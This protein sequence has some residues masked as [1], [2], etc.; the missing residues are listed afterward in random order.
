MH[1]LAEHP[2]KDNIQEEMENAKPIVLDTE[3]RAALREAVNTR[4]KNGC[5]TV[6]QGCL[7]SGPGHWEP[8]LNG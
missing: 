7:G 4:I 5:V 6:S 8:L 3:E 2:E 1:V